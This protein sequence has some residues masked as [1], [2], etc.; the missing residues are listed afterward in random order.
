MVIC[1]SNITEVR[2][3]PMMR[4]SEA[5]ERRRAGLMKH[6][7]DMPPFEKLRRVFVTGRPVEVKHTAVTAVAAAQDA[8]ARLTAKIAELN[9]A[10]VQ[11]EVGLVV[12]SRELGGKTIS[13]TMDA[14]AAAQ[15]VADIAEHTAPVIAGL[16][17][18]VADGKNY[19][20]WTKAF[21]KGR[22]VEKMLDLSV[23]E[24]VK[25]LRKRLGEIVDYS[26]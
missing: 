19:E 5:K 3:I 25:Q 18:A 2:N 13:V 15:S 21:L 10:N 22:L 17:F 9:L 1:G 7:N 26:A 6:L 8:L 14:K 16:V 12:F 23:A 11:P 4:V 24:Q 20:F